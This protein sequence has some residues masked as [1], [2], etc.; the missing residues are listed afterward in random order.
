MKLDY[1]FTIHIT[2]LIHVEKSSVTIEYGKS[3]SALNRQIDDPI[4]KHYD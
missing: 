1:N 2:T 4:S 3:N